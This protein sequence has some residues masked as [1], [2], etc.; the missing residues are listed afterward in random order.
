[1]FSNIGTIIWF[2]NFSWGGETLTID[3]ESYNF[4]TTKKSTRF[5]F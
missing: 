2:Y 3:K 5:Q 4:W 1:M